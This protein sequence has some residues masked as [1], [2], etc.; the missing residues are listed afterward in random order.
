MASARRAVAMSRDEVQAM[1]SAARKLQVAT[2]GRDGAPHLT[3]LFHAVDAG[4]VVFWTYGRSQKARNLRRDP[5]IS[6]LV[7]DGD[8]YAE[9][10]G[11]S[12]RGTAEIVDDPDEVRRIGA[13][14][15]ERTNGHIDEDGRRVVQAQAPKRVVVRVHP[16]QVASW[17]HRKLPVR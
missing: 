13:L 10:R 4:Q 14:L 15:Y 1:L 7:E 12:I 6:V 2:V 8:D 5:R 17:D 11:V 3:T 9:L 16:A